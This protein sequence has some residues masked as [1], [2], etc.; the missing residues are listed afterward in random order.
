M[1]GVAWGVGETDDDDGARRNV[2]KHTYEAT[3]DKKKC[4]FKCAALHVP[5]C[6]IVTSCFCFVVSFVCVGV[7]RLGGST[8]F[9]TVRH[10]E[11]R[12]AAALAMSSPIAGD[13]KK[14]KQN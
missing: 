9:G 5:R 10:W 6:Y 3:L 1:A 8:A 11:F 12:V 4:K 7:G 13:R 14:K 2:R